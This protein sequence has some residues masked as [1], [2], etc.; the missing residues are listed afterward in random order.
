MRPAG[1]D[2]LTGSRDLQGTFRGSWDLPEVASDHH[3]TLPQG[4]GTFRT[5]SKGPRTLRKQR[6]TTGNDSEIYE[7]T[8]IIKKEPIWAETGWESVH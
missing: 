4:P 8:K 5:V 1:P 3:N 2:T 7:I 6:Q